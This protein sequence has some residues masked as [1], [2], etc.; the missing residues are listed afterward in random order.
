MV[1]VGYFSTNTAGG[2]SPGVLGRE[3]EDR[4]YDSMWLP[5]HSHIPVERA[6]VPMFGTEVPD[7]YVHLMDP[8]V[9]LAVA[10]ANTSSL[11]LAT[12]VSMVLEHDLLDFA[13]RA[14]T[15]DVLCDG[16]LRLGVA[17][18]WLPEELAN[19]RPDIAWSSRYAAVSERVRALRTLW[20][21]EEPEFEG[22][23]E[24]F[25]KS[26]LYPKPI[27]RPLPVGYGYS[28]LQGMRLAAEEADEW[29]P[30]D[31]VLAGTAGS[32]SEGITLFRAL[33]TDAGRRPEEV[34]VTMFCWGWEPGQP[35]IENLKE[36]ADL[37]IER[38]VVC[39]P[40]MQRHSSDA[41]L[42]RLDEFMPL[43]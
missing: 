43:V 12:G 28:G 6:P 27:Q 39:P 38:I 22:R 42:R 1:R 9:S 21:D 36:Y 5:E 26:W 13:C 14:A 24:R 10:A 32:V 16:R 41:T 8:F 19:H 31:G 20:Q 30:I 35:S 34:P 7:A 11:I 29:Y 40:T 25:T 17:V 33:V 18:G 2:I 3:L 15:L 4:G 23:W 37:G